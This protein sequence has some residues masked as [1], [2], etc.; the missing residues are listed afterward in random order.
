MAAEQKN[1][2]KSRGIAESAMPRVLIFLVQGFQDGGLAG[3][4]GRCDVGILQGVVDRLD[5]GLLHGSV[6]L[7]VAVN[8]GALGTHMRR[9]IAGIRAKR[10]LI[11]RSALSG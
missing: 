4:L 10:I 2:K 1:D 8:D 3:G 6:D 11:E 5:D 7:Q 9:N